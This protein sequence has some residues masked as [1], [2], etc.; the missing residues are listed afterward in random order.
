[1]VVPPWHAIIAKLKH[2]PTCP[3][4]NQTRVLLSVM[5]LRNHKGVFHMKGGSKRYYRPQN[6]LLDLGVQPLMLGKVVVEGLGL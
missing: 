2:L 4:I 6:I 1:M 5:V 3:P